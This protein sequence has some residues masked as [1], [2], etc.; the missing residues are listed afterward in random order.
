MMDEYWSVITVCSTL[1]LSVIICE[2]Y[3]SNNSIF[4][5][6]TLFEYSLYYSLN[7]NSVYRQSVG[8]IPIG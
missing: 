1:L 4:F 5:S 7:Q 8:L 3:M 6:L 2:K